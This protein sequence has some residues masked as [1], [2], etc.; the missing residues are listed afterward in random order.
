MSTDE[1]LLSAALVIVAAV[2]ARGVAQRLA[3]GP[4]VAL[5]V[6]GAALGPHSVYPLLADYTDEMQAVGEV[7]VVLLLFLMGLD[8][9]PERLRSMRTLVF[10]SAIVLYLLTVAALV[11]V[12]LVL[13]FKSWQAALIVALGLAM[14]STAVAVGTLEERSESMTAHGRAVMA[15]LISQGFIAILV[16]AAIPMLE[17]GPRGAPGV[18]APG[19]VLMVLAIVATVYVAARKVLPAA[20]TWSARRLGSNGFGMIVLAAVFAAAWI[21]DQIGASMALGSFMVGMILSTSQFA[22]QIRT[23]VAPR[24]GILLGVLFIAIGMSIDPREV[25]GVGWHLFAILPL[26]LLIKV[27]FVALWYLSRLKYGLIS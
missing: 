4:I 14:G 26:L 10:G 15:V 9:Q 7:G 13:G 25:A 21:M 6:V 1:I 11:A 20:L 24:K 3:L 18:P 8:T 27:A 16:L 2:V 23:A 19:K 12:F 5:L 22:E 17:A